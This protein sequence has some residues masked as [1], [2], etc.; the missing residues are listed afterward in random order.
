MGKDPYTCLQWSNRIVG[1]ERSTLGRDGILTGD[2]LEPNLRRAWSTDN[3]HFS[4]FSYQ[5]VVIDGH[6]FIS[7]SIGVRFLPPR[8]SNGAKTGV[9]GFWFSCFPLLFVMTLQVLLHICEFICVG[10]ASSALATESHG[11]H[12]G[13]MGAYMPLHK[14]TSKFKIVLTG[15]LWFT[16]PICQAFTNQEAEVDLN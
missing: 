14:G 3:A 15:Y 16:R 8:A 4:G 6:Y 12:H 13:R 11:G 9:L 7:I 5:D 1:P 10:V 2:I